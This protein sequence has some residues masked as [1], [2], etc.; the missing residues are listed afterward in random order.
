M[1]PGGLRPSH[2]GVFGYAKCLQNLSDDT[3]FPKAGFRVHACGSD[4]CTAD[5]AVT[6]YNSDPPLAHGRVVH[7]CSEDKRLPGLKKFSLL[8]PVPPP[9]WRCLPLP[10][11]ALASG[12][13][14]RSSSSSSSRRSSSCSSSISHTVVEHPSPTVAG[15]A[16]AR[17]KSSPADADY[18]TPMIVGEAVA[19]LPP[20]V[21]SA[22]IQSTLARAAEVKQP[23]RLTG[24]L[25]L[26]AFCALRKRRLYAHLSQGWHDIMD[27]FA[28]G[29]V[30]ATWDANPLRE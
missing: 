8:A 3:P 20:Q 12:E 14:S 11:P 4:P 28:P 13:G 2:N 7:L 27:V 17:G 18:D 16:A 29:L 21:S 23:R 6:K 1:G 9:A 5:Y 25:D 26:V 30:D 22:Q 24:C 19:D 10:P 15:E